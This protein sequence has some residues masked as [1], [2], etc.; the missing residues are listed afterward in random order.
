MFTY[1]IIIIGTVSFYYGLIYKNALNIH[2][3]KKNCLSTVL[4]FNLL[5]DIQTFNKN[6]HLE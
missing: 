1:T 3:M 5:T 4:I 6:I 2:W